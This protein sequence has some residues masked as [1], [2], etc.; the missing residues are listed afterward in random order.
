M[1][2][3]IYKED[4]DI[5]FFAEL[6]LN[7][8][9]TLTHLLID[10]YPY[11]TY[12]KQERDRGHYVYSKYRLSGHEFI[13]QSDLKGLVLKTMV[14]V[15]TDSV[16]IYGCHLASNNYDSENKY[17]TPDS[18]ATTKNALKYLKNI[19]RTSAIRVRECD[20]IIC[21]MRK[22]DTSCIVLGDLNDV[23]GS[24]CMQVF[25]DAGLHDTWWE[26]GDGYGATIRYLLPYRIDH[27]LYSNGLKLKSIKRVNAKGLSDH[28]ALVA[29]FY[30]E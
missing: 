13:Y 8:S 11:T 17:M 29:D 4:P 26:G 14:Y 24:P 23:C 12:V 20:S 19:K 3:A 22:Y 2:E 27:V 30:F 21:D 25:E 18:V 9:D 10:R 28:D 6:F 16:V 1:A 7:A 5:L 15:R